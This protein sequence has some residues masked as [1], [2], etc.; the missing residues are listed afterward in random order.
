MRRCWHSSADPLAGTGCHPGQR[1]QPFPLRS[2][3]LPADQ[4]PAAALAA[5]R[6]HPGPRDARLRPGRAAALSRRPAGH[7]VPVPL[8][9]LR[10][11]GPRRSSTRPRRRPARSPTAARRCHRAGPGPAGPSSTTRGGRSGQYE[12]FFSA[13]SG[14]EFAA[15]TGV[16]TVVFYDPPGRVG[17]HAASRQQLGEG[18]LRSLVRAAVGRQR[19]RAG[20]PIRATDA[21]V[22]NYFQRLLGTGAVHV[23]VRAADRRHVR[24]DARGPGR[25][26]GRG[27]EGRRAR[28]HPGGQ[29]LRLGGPGL[30][31]GRGQRRRGALSRAARPTTR[32]AAARRHRRAGPADRGIRLPATRS[33]AADSGTWPEATWP[34]VPCT[35]S[36]RRRR[37]ARPGQRRRPADPQLGC[38]R[39]RVPA[40]STTR[41]SGRRTATS[42]R[43]ARPRSSSTWSVYGEGQPAANLC[44]RT[45]RHYDMAGYTENSRYDYTG[46][47]GVQRPAARRG[48]SPGHRLD[49][50]RRPD[51]RRR[52]G[53]RRGRRGAGADR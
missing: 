18:G 41:R 26:A 14:F 5:G 6:V 7:E 36:T 19:H 42:A 48:L 1:H 30:P 25:R 44:G 43:A 31:G 3:R 52:T 38:A 49:A 27:A 35:G 34:A 15:Q 8:R 23:L 10:R 28:R 2:R 12:P 53:R 29:P 21:D 47:P 39:P 37:A 4:H 17:G 50:A 40:A 45:F 13:T 46:Q 33:P 24:H 9:L 51:H 16:S 32:R 11:L 20:R 22:G